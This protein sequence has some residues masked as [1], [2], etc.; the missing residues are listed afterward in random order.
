MISQTLLALP[1]WALFELGLVFAKIYARRDPD[2]DTGNARA[3]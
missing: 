3:G 1:V 2:E